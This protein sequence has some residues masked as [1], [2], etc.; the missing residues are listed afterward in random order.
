[1]HH[2]PSRKCGR[3]KIKGDILKERAH[4]EIS[5]SDRGILPSSSNES[6]HLSVSS[7]SYSLFHSSDWRLQLTL[8]KSF[9]LSGQENTQTL[10]PNNNCENKRATELAE[11]QGQLQSLIKQGIMGLYGDYHYR[12]LY[13]S[14]TN[15]FCPPEL[16]LNDSLRITCGCRT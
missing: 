5:A 13:E 3:R 16:M 6:A 4:E 10:P 12:P 8:V 1:M 2:A 9:S 14:S 7:E 15:I 11:S